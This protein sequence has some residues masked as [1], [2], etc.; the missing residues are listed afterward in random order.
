MVVA[1]SREEVLEIL[2]GDIYTRTGVWDLDK[3]Q[4]WPVS[5]FFQR[6]RP[7]S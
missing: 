3:I 7:R 6:T 4:I 2:K 1:E 5:L